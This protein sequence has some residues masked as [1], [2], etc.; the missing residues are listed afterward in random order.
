MKPHVGQ[1]E[2]KKFEQ[3]ANQWLDEV[4]HELDE[5]Q[6]SKVQYADARLKAA[7]TRMN[8]AGALL[9]VPSSIET[10]A[11]SSITLNP[12]SIFEVEL[13]K[14]ETLAHEWLQMA[15]RREQRSLRAKKPRVFH[16]EA[17]A[18]VTTLRDCASKVLDMYRC[19]NTGMVL[20]YLCNP[21]G[22]ARNTRQQGAYK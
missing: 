15:T 20:E 22:R 14:I 18:E 2:L 7:N 16:A 4:E 5:I 17:I 10:K 21:F 11:I 9:V 3:L 8:C 1:L 13:R 6:A 12:M 19:M